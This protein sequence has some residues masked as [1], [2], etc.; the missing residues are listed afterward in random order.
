MRLNK[1][2]VEKL[3]Q[4]IE[5]IKTIHTISEDEDAMLA[6]DVETFLAHTEDFLYELGVIDK[7]Y[8]N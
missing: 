4:M 2:Q 1:E 8:F 3:N 7:M 6:D 5:S